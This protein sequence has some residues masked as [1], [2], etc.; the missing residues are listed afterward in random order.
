MFVV[1]ASVFNHDRRYVDA[2]DLLELQSHR[3]SKAAHTASEIKRAFFGSERMEGLDVVKRR[4]DFG[5]SGLEELLGVPA[6]VL[7][8]RVR[9]HGPQ[10]IALTE[11]IPM[12]LK[13]SKV[14]S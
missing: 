4:I 1:S 10:R 14:Q 12:L 5:Q 3:L 13:Q 2:V 8:F 11:E 7:F 6:G 9:K